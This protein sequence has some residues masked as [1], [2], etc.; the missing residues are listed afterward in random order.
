MLFI[1]IKKKKKNVIFYKQNQA[2]SVEE[3]DDTVANF[4][5]L[6]EAMLSMHISHP[7]VVLSYKYRH[8]NAGQDTW[9]FF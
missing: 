7:N 6:F 2:Y 1:L 8:V 4:N 5:P 3:E 9:V